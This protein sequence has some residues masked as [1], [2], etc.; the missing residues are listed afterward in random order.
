[1]AVTYYYNVYLQQ[2]LNGVWVN[3]ETQTAKINFIDFK[4]SGNVQ[5]SPTDQAGNQLGSQSQLQWAIKAYKKDGTTITQLNDDQVR[6]VKA[7]VPA[8]PVNDILNGIQTWNNLY[9]TAQINKA[10]LNLRALKFPYM[11]TPSFTV[12]HKGATGFPANG[13]SIPR[14]DIVGKDFTGVQT[15]SFT[16][17]EAFPAIPKGLIAELDLEYAGAAPIRQT[18]NIHYDSDLKQYV[19]IKR[20]VNTTTQ[21]TTYFALYYNPGANGTKVKEVEIGKDPKKFLN[22]SKGPAYKA[23]M[24]VL[25]DAIVSGKVTNVKVPKDS[26]GGGGGGGNVAPK[27]PK[28]KERWNPPFHRATKGSTRSFEWVKKDGKQEIVNRLSA[29]PELGRIYQDTNSALAVNINPEISKKGQ[30]WGFRF[31]YNPETINYSV[32]GT[33]FDY[34]MGAADAAILIT[35][36]MSINLSLLINRQADMVELLSTNSPTKSP[37]TPELSEAARLGIL[38]RGTEYDL[39]FLYRVCNGDPSTTTGQDP[40]LGYDG[41]TSD[42]GL[43]KQTP[44]WMHL[45]N[46]YKI[47]G[48]VSNLDV[49]HRVFDKRMV[50]ILTEVKLTINRYPA[51]VQSVEDLNT[52]VSEEFKKRYSGGVVPPPKDG[53]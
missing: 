53:E 9:F 21:E 1:M 40:L 16:K 15:V 47:F 38:N 7:T 36:N 34:T 52:P 11:I 30:L 2:H 49:T 5:V 8:N 20:V 31:M 4:D 43:L 23:A 19:G 42:T 13:V 10:V 18:Q 51:I 39:E 44:V 17:A 3:I 25:I 35:G 50:P 6:V 22:G 33:P 14:A 24:A 29:A 41:L 46:S 37:Y 48:A 45:H 32:S 28:D 27:E 26:D 12:T